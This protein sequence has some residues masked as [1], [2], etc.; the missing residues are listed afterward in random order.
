MTYLAVHGMFHLLGYDHMTEEDK[1][2]MRAK[3]R[4]GFACYK[5][6]R[7]AISINPVGEH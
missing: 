5:F 6:S 4:R 1:A 2:E 3:E 7:G